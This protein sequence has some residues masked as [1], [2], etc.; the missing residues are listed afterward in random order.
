MAFKTSVKWI[1]KD[2]V[3]DRLEFDRLKMYNLEQE[4]DKKNILYIN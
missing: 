4:P 1:M 2:N 3:S